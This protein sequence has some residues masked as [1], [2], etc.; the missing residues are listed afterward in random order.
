LNSSTRTGS[1]GG[2]SGAAEHHSSSGSSRQQPVESVVHS[3]YYAS[4]LVALSHAVNSNTQGWQGC[5][6][7]VT[8]CARKLFTYGTQQQQHLQVQQPA[9]SPAAFT[10]ATAAS[11]ASPAAAALSAAAVSQLPVKQK[12][13]PPHARAATAAQSP[14]KPSRDKQ[15][16]QLQDSSDDS[17]QSAS[18]WS[19]VSDTE[20]FQGRGGRRS[21]NSRERSQLQQQ[22]QLHDPIN[23]V[24]VR[25]ALLQLLQV[26]IQA[27]PRALHPYW[28]ALLPGQAPLQRSPLSPHLLTV[29]LYD[30]SD[31]VSSTAQ[32]G[33]EVLFADAAVVQ[34]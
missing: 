20:C 12:Y 34:T 24:R 21:S 32:R 2:S 17:E 33:Q 9:R 8:E 26:L 25:S 14:S 31:K 4:L 11:H 5:A 27:D 15:Q 29:L 28:A 13:V 1:S 18:D 23:A 22:Q 6:G 16:Q 30:P 3:Q 10:A 7:A 19:D